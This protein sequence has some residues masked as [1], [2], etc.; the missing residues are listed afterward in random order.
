MN[1][2][3][4]NFQGP[5]AAHHSQQ[6]TF[7]RADGARLTLG[8]FDKV[9][10]T[11]GSLTEGYVQGMFPYP[12]ARTE[13]QQ[14][15]LVPFDFDLAYAS[16][17]EFEDWLC[18]YGDI[19]TQINIEVDVPDKNG[20]L[21]THTY[22]GWQYKD[23]KTGS[24]RGGEPLVKNFTGKALYQTV[25]GQTQIKDGVPAG[26]SIYVKAAITVAG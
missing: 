11:Q 15:G 1:Y 12:V 3:D 7:V 16:G 9:D 13:A 18:S 4:G 19:R 26:V 6:I 14:D 22:H 25:D 17:M 21:R 5:A 10:A 8:L 24:T 20:F 2:Q 23:C